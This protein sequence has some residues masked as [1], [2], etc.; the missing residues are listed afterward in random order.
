MDE[1]WSS[2]IA[3]AAGGVIGAFGT[4]GVT[5]WRDSV[6]AKR[7]TSA[8]LGMVSVE[9]DENR[10]RI[11]RFGRDKVKDLLTLHDWGMNKVTLAEHLEPNNKDL[12]EELVRVFNTIFEARDNR[13]NV[14]A[15]S[16][17]ELVDLKQKLDDHRRRHDHPRS[18]RARDRLRA[19]PPE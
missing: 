9:L 12:W 18:F 8:A 4:G 17:A 19:S 6:H 10:D 16:P 5:S 14:L 2:L 1:P 13:T 11:E 15:P 3:G 7:R